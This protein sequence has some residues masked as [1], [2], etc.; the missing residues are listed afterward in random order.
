MPQCLTRFGVAE[1]YDSVMIASPSEGR[2]NPDFSINENDFFA[3]LERELNTGPESDPSNPQYFARAFAEEMTNKTGSVA[4]NAACVEARLDDPHAEDANLQVD[5]ANSV[6]LYQRGR[7]AADSQRIA[8]FVF[9]PAGVE[10]GLHAL[11]VSEDDAEELRIDIDYW[12]YKFDDRPE[13]VTARYEADDLQRVLDVLKGAAVDG[14]PIQWINFTRVD[15]KRIMEYRESLAE[16]DDIL[17]RRY[18]EYQPN[19]AIDLQQLSYVVGDVITQQELMLAGAIANELIWRQF[20]AD[21]ISDSDNENVE[22][23][24]LTVTDRGLSDLSRGFERTLDDPEVVPLF[25]KQLV[26]D[27]PLL[28][29]YMHQ[30]FSTRYAQSADNLQRAKKLQY[31]LYAAALTARAIRLHEE[32]L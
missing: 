17:R 32:E 27:Q 11:H 4:P 1:C 14:E 29:T 3:Q 30:E 8:T 22:R 16:N 6:I 5:V 9:F 13:D 24:T 23:G 26:N 31:W 20:L 10:S 19:L 21:S 28:H 2:N 25:I 15:P 12:K 18:Q 7:C